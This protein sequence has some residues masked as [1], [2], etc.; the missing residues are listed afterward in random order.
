MRYIPSFANMH[1]VDDSS[2][3]AVALAAITVSAAAEEEEGDGDA[4]A[5][6]KPCI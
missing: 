4:A 1:L 5:D 3:Q 2:V 6:N